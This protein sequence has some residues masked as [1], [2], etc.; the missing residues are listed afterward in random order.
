[1]EAIVNNKTGPWRRTSIQGLYEYRRPDL[2]KA[3][4]G[5][6]FSR[7]S[8]NGNATFRSL[9]TR[10]FEHAKIKHAKRMVDVEKDRQRGADLGGEFK[11]LGALFKEVERR[12]KLNQVAP[13]TQV[14]RTNNL[15]RLKTH[16]RGGTGADFETFLARNV[17][18][19]VIG[20]LRDYL[21]TRAPWRYNF[22]TVHHGF[23]PY[24]VNVTLWVLDIML[25]IAVEKMVIMENPFKVS[26]TLQG[27]LKAG[28]SGTRRRS[29][30]GELVELL[31]NIPARPDMI[32]LLAEIRRVPEN[33]DTFRP[34][35]LQREYLQAV[36][37]EMA[38][39]A[40]LLA[41]SGMRKSECRNATIAD[42]LG[43]EF[44]IRGTKSESS[45]RRVPVTAALR[46]VLDR[47]KSRRIG[48]DTRLVITSELCHAL[49][50]ACRR[51]GLRHVRVH[52]LRHF[53]ASACIASGV[54]IPTVS[55]WLGHA[56]GGALAM[57]T[58][59]HLLKDHS[60][61]AAKKVDFSGDHAPVSTQPTPPAPLGQV[62]DI[63]APAAQST[64]A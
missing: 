42:D 56:D 25:A 59:G 12:M 35:P 55:R 64:S 39:H 21:I 51:L 34:N 45:F 22:G 24:V 3:A 27:S 58:Y 46:A 18:A 17:D 50:R 6:Y 2:P 49:G 9:E 40:E 19:A 26:R 16:W 60:L 57:K 52:D 43:D 53:F 47:I 29:R 8:I 63:T 7:F 23:K 37:N 62:I 4:R 5:T 30:S 14:G 15:A 1:M 11:T 54:D 33:S 48:A 20:R 13:S 44:K 41:F 32:R 38:D 31:H 36:A 61:A 28:G 10:N